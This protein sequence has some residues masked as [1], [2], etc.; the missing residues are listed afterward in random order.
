MTNRVIFVDAVVV[1]VV[2]VV[3]VVCGFVFHR[4]HLSSFIAFVI[5]PSVGTRIGQTLLSLV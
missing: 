5:L 4:F 3:V 2:V 1:G